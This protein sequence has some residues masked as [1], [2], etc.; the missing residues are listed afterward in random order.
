MAPSLPPLADAVAR[1]SRCL[2]L[3]MQLGRAAEVAAARAVGFLPYAL[4][5]MAAPVAAA[6]GLGGLGAAGGARRW[7]ALLRL[8][9]GGTGPDVGLPDRD[10][11]LLTAA[12][13]GGVR[14]IVW[15]TL[16]RW[17]TPR[18]WHAGSRCR[19]LVP[20]QRVGSQHA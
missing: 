16:G 19:Q 12:L 9:E 5:E 11:P 14:Y 8:P 1:L 4:Q 20:G 10:D 2:V 15:W 7:S 17:A 18:C 3:R 6:E 13:T